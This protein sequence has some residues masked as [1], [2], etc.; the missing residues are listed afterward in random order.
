M[1]KFNK[2]DSK[3]NIIECS[4]SEEKEKLLN[5][6][7]EGEKEYEIQIQEEIHSLIAKSELN[8]KLEL[9]FF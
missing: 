5:F 1:E 6:L 9:Y 2:E 4:S 7:F 8:W 3:M